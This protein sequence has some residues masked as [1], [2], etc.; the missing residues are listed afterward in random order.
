MRGFT[1]DHVFFLF[2][3]GFFPLSL[4]PTLFL[5][6]SKASAL[7]APLPANVQLISFQQVGDGTTTDTVLIRLAHQFGID[8]DAILSQPVTVDLAQLFNA[9]TA[10]KIT[11]AVEYSLT[12]N[13]P[14]AEIMRKRKQAREWH[15]DGVESHPWRLLA[16]LDY[17]ADTTVVLGPLEI[18]TFLLTVSK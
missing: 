4:F 12:A 1:A 11:N 9:S 2:F 18:K 10:F 16:P 17:A 5:I 6:H 7:S 13:Q 15:N 14:K 8:E 3:G